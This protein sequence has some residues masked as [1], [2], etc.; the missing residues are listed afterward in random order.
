MT[1]TTRAAKTMAVALA[2]AGLL[3]GCGA[4]TC[5]TE[6]AAVNTS[7]APQC[8]APA[9][10]TV[11]VTVQLCDYCSLT[12]PTCDVDLSALATNEIHLDTMWEACPDNSSCA[13]SRCEAVTCTFSVAPGTYTVYANTTASLA[14]FTLNTSSGGASCTSFI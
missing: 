4:T 12:S 9:P 13:T 3:A 5:P 1:R 14:S 11:S 2:A 10:Q 8:A 7:A 6:A